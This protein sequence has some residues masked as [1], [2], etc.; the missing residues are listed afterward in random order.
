MNDKEQFESAISRY[1]ERRHG[2]LC[3]P[4]ISPNL[5]A[6]ASTMS[7]THGELCVR[8]GQEVITSVIGSSTILNAVLRLGLIPVFVDVEIPTYNANPCLVEEA[9]NANTGAILLPHTLGNPVSI[10]YIEDRIVDGSKI[11]SIY[12]CRE[13]MGGIYT[14]TYEGH[15][16]GSY[17]SL[18]TL[19]F[20]NKGVIL[21]DSSMIYLVLK[22]VRRNTENHEM[23]ERLERVKKHSEEVRAR[24]RNWQFF[25][26]TLKDEKLDE[27]FILPEPHR[28]ADP[29]WYGFCLTC[30]DINVKKLLQYLN[31]KNVCA[32]KLHIQNYKGHKIVDTTRNIDIIREKSFWIDVDENVTSKRESIVMTIK[33]GVRL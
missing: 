31:N 18:S 12:D 20:G 32:H 21:T 11:W 6:L 26:K 22:Y 29:N 9:V 14:G 4:G 15:P 33:N 8:R 28:L 5:L 17:G 23:Q 19:C 30:R 3:H 16:I 7:P 2:I 25:Y 24:R 13:A 27:Y 1:N 10:S